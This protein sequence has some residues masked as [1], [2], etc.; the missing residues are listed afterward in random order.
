[1]IDGWNFFDESIKNN[2]ITYNNI[3]MIASGQGEDY[4]TGFP[5]DHNYFTYYYKI[6]AID[7]SKQEALVADPKAIQQINFT[8]N[9]DCKFQ[10]FVKLFHIIL[11][12][13]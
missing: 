12:L 2:L 5:L 1:M 13:I 4:T 6:I 10:G 3:Q 11:Q 9:L 8:A 7:L